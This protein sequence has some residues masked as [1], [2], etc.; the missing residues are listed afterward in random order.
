MGTVRK[1]TVPIIYLFFVSLSAQLAVWPLIAYYFNRVSLVSPFAN[2]L[3]LCFGL[4]FTAE[5]LPFISPIFV[6][7]CYLLVKLLISI[8]GLFAGLPHA[9]VETP[10]PSIL[11]I[12]IYY[13][14]LI[15]IFK[16]RLLPKARV[17]P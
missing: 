4:F 9:V 10:Q 14:L 11:F 15:F 3:W 13:V 7:A 17:S 5:L 2:L 12:S 1:G 16:M 8:T 6:K